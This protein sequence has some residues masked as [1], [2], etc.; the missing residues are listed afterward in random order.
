MG[1]LLI[2]GML[3]VFKLIAT[4]LKATN[5]NCFNKELNL[6]YKEI[7]Y[8]AANNKKIFLHIKEKNKDKIVFFDYCNSR[9][10]N[11]IV[12]NNN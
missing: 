5:A 3:V 8:I 7:K 10:I 12:L 6:K 1:V 11:E 2:I 4:K 9:D